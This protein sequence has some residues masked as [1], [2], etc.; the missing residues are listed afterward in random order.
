MAQTQVNFDVDENLK[1]RFEASI[2]NLGYSTMAESFREFMR[3]M[4]NM[5]SPVSDGNCTKTA[6]ATQENSNG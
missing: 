2:K 1:T 6:T 5:S 4:A 3:G